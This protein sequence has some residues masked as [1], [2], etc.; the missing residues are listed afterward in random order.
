MKKYTEDISQ[1]PISEKLDEIIST[2]KNSP[3]RFLILTAETA[4]GKSTILPLKLIEEFSDK[5]KSKKKEGLIEGD[6]RGDLDCNNK[7]L[8]TEPRRLAVLGVANRLADL[9]GENIGQSIGYKIHLDKKITNKTKAEIVTEAILVRQ[10]QNDSI[11]EGYNLVVLDEFHER[12]VNLDLA[13]AFLKEA[14]ELRDDLFVVIMSATIDTDKLQAYLGKETP[15]FSVKGRQY[16]V[17]IIYD[18]KSTVEKAIKKELDRYNCNI[19]EINRDNIL[20]FLPGIKEIRKVQENLLAEKIIDDN[21]EICILHSSISLEEQK[22]I[23]KEGSKRRVILSSAIGETS[24]TVPGVS[25]V[26][27]CGLARINR[28]NVGS[29]M[30]GLFT[31]VESDFSATQRMGRAGRLKPGRCIRLWSQA[32]PRIKDMPCEILRADLTSLVLECADRGIYSVDKICWLDSPPLAAWNSCIELLKL[33]GMIKEDGR[34][35]EKGKSA[36]L[37]GIHPRLAGIALQDFENGKDIILKYSSYSKST[38]GI[39]KRFLN[40]LEN[41]IKKIK[42]RNYEQIDSEENFIN[43]KNIVTLWGYGDR[44]CKRISDVG[45]LPE[46]YKFPSGKTAIL[47]EN[48]QGSQWIVAPDIIINSGNA[49]IYDFEKLNSVDVE[50]WLQDRKV[51]REECVFEN[52]KIKKTEN[53]CFGNIILEEKKIPSDQ[54]DFVKAWINEIKCKGLEC[55]PLNNKSKSLILRGE[56]LWENSKEYKREYKRNKKESSINFSEYIIDN[57]EQWLPPFLATSNKLTE[58][59]M[60]N[61]LYWFISGEIIDKDAPETIILENGKK[62]KIKYE[63]LASPTNRHLLIIR[64]VIEIIIQRIFGCRKTPEICGVKSLL[65]LLSPAQR[66]LQIT[67]DLEGFWTGA[68]QEICKEMKGRYP[69]HNW[70]EKICTEKGD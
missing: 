10:L 11:L 48:K 23:L 28:M 51:V 52:G 58:E 36:L 46:I 26:I 30:E 3:S 19:G 40:D 66:P 34:I 43:K 17:E 29:G 6:N 2:L 59:I 38:V 67:D 53:I 44:L 12:S 16:P 31:E 70:N 41:R 35:S 69:K 20:V 33:L 64:P 42:N 54:G 68:W 1:F 14:M 56:F 61:S 7:I 55:C 25:T 37:L 15:V 22:R 62:A 50:N 45:L 57:V 63:K 13:L 60:Y 65:R 27:D 5:E 18:D 9:I 39:Q 21:T 32:N 24:I 49:I 8:I 47:G 4:A